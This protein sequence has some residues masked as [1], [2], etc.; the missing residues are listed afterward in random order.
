V[1]VTGKEFLPLATTHWYQDGSVSATAELPVT[2]GMTRI[3]RS[4]DVFN[5]Y[6]NPQRI[7]QTTHAGTW[8][9]T[10]TNVTSLTFTFNG[11]PDFNGIVTIYR[12]R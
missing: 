8:L 2:T 10:T 7:M 9:D 4:D 1:Q 6:Q 3:I 11:A 12:M 5:S